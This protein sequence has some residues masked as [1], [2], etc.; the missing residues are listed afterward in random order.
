MPQP[1]E[2][3]AEIKGIFHID[4]VVSSQIQLRLTI[5]FVTR[6]FPSWPRESQKIQQKFLILFLPITPLNVYKSKKLSYFY[7]SSYVN[8][9]LLKISQ[10][11]AKYLDY[12]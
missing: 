10:I 11:P 2:L 5:F 3:L 1:V 12:F 6:P 4:S 8:F 9:G 7:I